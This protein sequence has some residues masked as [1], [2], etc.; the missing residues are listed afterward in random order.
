[1]LLDQSGF[2]TDCGQAF[3]LDYQL[4]LIVQFGLGSIGHISEPLLT[5]TPADAA[6]ANVADMQDHSEQQQAVIRQH[7]QRRGYK[8]AV[9]NSHLPGCHQIDYGHD[10][11]PVVSI[12]IV[13]HDRLLQIQRCLET[14]LENTGYSKYELLLL[15]HGN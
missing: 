5:A 8:Y 3:E 7:L 6:A 15:D 10:A 1:T 14:L 13:V 4:R 9:V 11:Q 2:A 12:L